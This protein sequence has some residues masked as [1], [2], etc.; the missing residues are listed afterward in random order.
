M[1][2]W[3]AD[4]PIVVELV[5]AVVPEFLSD[6]ALYPLKLPIVLLIVFY[7]IFPIPGPYF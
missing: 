3:L 6:G 1:I 4:Y 2:L 5:A 7:I